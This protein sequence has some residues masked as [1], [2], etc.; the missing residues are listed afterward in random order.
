MSPGT[1]SE[2]VNPSL[3][4][5]AANTIFAAS[6]TLRLASAAA[7]RWFNPRLD[8]FAHGTERGDLAFCRLDFGGASLGRRFECRTRSQ[9]N[10]E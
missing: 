3:S 9:R 5:R 6:A 4:R 7:W 2:S 10:S 1:H 8:L